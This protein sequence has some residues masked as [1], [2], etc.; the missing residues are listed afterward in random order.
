MLS[1]LC[2][3]DVVRFVQR[4]AARLHQKRAKLLTCALRSFLQ[5]VRYWGRPNSRVTR[6]HLDSFQR[7]P[8]IHIEFEAA[9]RVHMI[10]D[11]RRQCSQIS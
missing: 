10:P 5:Y 6:G 4:Q 7:Q 9:I 11:Q 8:V 1:H 3:G 2:A